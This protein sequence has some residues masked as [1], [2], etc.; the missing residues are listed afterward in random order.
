MATGLLPEEA[1]G[2]W[3]RIPAEQKRLRRKVVWQS[4]SAQRGECH[5]VENFFP[6]YS[7]LKK[8]IHSNF[9]LKKCIRGAKR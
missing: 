1:G 4:C 6:R 9:P 2:L 8:F 7:H 5:A 3:Q